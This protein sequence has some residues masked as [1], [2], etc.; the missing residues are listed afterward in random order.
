MDEVLDADEVGGVMAGLGS[1]TTATPDAYD[2]DRV[3]VAFTLPHRGHDGIPGAPDDSCA[4]CN[5]ERAFDRI[6]AAG[7]RAEEARQEAI[8]TAARAMDRTSQVEAKLAAAEEALRQLHEWSSRMP[9]A[10]FND[11]SPRW[12]WWHEKPD[13]RAALAAVPEENQ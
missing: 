6:V 3:L 7:V 13:V 11:Q 8:G 2:V 5:A 4:R 10:G 9:D 12:K 1:R